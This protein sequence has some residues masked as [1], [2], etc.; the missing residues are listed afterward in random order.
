MKRDKF[1]GCH[2][3]INSRAHIKS[4]YS[5][6]TQKHLRWVLALAYTPTQNFALALSTCWY[7]KMLKFELPPTLWALRPYS[8]ENPTPKKRVKLH[9]MYMSN[10]KIMHLG[11]NA[12]YIPLTRVGV[13][14]WG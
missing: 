13:L 4:L 6:A 2:H 8:T 1:A 11:S 10:A 12:T 3:K 14:R 5:T 7:L 9:K